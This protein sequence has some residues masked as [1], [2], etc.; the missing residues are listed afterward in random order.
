MKKSIYIICTALICLIGCIEEYTP[1]DIEE[2]KDLLVVDGIITNGEST[3][4]VSQSVG[5]QEELYEAKLVNDAELYVETEEGDI[6]PSQ[7][8]G[9]GIYTVQMGELDPAKQYRLHIAAN[10]EVYKS[11]F[12]SPLFAPAIDTIFSEKPAKGKPV[13]LYLMT[14]DSQNQNKYY[15]WSFEEHWEVQAELFANAGYI[16]DQFMM[17]YLNTPYNT[18]YCWGKDHSKKLILGTTD[19]ISE[20]IISR[21]KLTEIQPTDDRLSIL[22]YISVKQSSLRKEAYAFFQNLQK[23]VELTGGLF[24][25]IPSE[26]KGNISCTTNPNIYVVGYIEVSTTTEKELYIDK[27][28]KYYELTYG[29]TCLDDDYR[30]Y[31][32]LP[33]YSIYEYYSSVYLRTKCVDCRTRYNASKNKPDFWPTSSQ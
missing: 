16:D 12:L 5:L 17:F 9:D 4:K 19:K 32:P 8:S 27:S 18:Y 3:F 23:N 25:A 29:S 22:Y 24:S 6:F 7:R 33:G 13:S 31:T 14:H 1:T 10:N 11:S 30:R 20:N 21:Q 2:I 28:K 26:M 15:R